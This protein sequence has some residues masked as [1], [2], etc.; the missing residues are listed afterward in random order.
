MKSAEIKARTHHGMCLAIFAGNGYKRQK[1]S[2]LRESA[3]ISA[4]AAN[5]WRFTKERS[6]ATCRF[7]TIW[8]GDPV[9]KDIVTASPATLREK[10][11]GGSPALNLYIIKKQQKRDFFVP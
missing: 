8:R 11:L 5:G 9:K 1:R 4:E 6:I 7:R 2:F 10:G 3:R